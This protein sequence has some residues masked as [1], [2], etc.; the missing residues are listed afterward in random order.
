MLPAHERFKADDVSVRRRLRLI[1]QAKL[2]ALQRR[3][4]IVLQAPL[5]AQ[6]LVHFGREEADGAAPLRLCPVKCRVR[7]AEQRR[8]VLP[9]MGIDCDADA[10]ANGDPMALDLQI[11]RH[12]G[13]NALGDRN[14]WRLLV[15]ALYEDRE[16]I[17]SETS[18]E[19]AVHGGE[20]PVRYLP[21]HKIASRM[22]EQIVDL[23]E[24]VEV[25]AQNRKA[26]AAGG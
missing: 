1:E 9:V 19:L 13:K 26:G 10:D 11:F 14:S 12:G 17:S 3:A 7:V 5:R 20:Q 2:A 21:K 25:D 15:A 4:Q 16:F 23:L 6:L 18:N 8:S 22:P 24:A